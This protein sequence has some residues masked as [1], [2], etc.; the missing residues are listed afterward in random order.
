M[1]AVHANLG[2]SQTAWR[3]SN[4]ARLLMRAFALAAYVACIIAQQTAGPAREQ[5]VCDDS[6]RCTEQ[7]GCGANNGVC[8]EA[9][10]VSSQIMQGNYDKDSGCVAGHCCAPRTDGSD[11]IKEGHT[12]CQ[13]ASIDHEGAPEEERHA[14][15]FAKYIYYAYFVVGY[16]YVKGKLP[17]IEGEVTRQQIRAAHR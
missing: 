16:L 3:A 5:E 14:P 11:C 6:C 8:D 10:A 4:A 12:T 2:R 9:A 7:Q 1:I 17:A 13:L 15:S